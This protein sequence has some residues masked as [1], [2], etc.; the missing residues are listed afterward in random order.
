MLLLSVVILA[1]L[2]GVVRGGRISAFGGHRWRLPAL[3][4]LALGAQI[5]AFLPDESASHPARMFA[6]V[7]HIVSYLIMLTFVWSNRRTSWI[8]L[9]GLGLAANTAVILA[10]GGFMP[11][12]P[13]A[14]EGVADAR[15]A[16]AG[17]HNNSVLLDQ[18]T[19][20][21]A[22]GDVFQ[23]PEWL[24]LRREFSGGDSLVAIGAFALVQ[25]LMRAHRGA[26]EAR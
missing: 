9:I 25:R 11:V 14:L 10:N 6:A 15:V 5:L 20:L 7:L 1:L 26:G 3:P 21:W 23:T 2:V 4:F 22:L 13:S 24:P 19:R 12:A 18:G 17:V 8:W 16:A